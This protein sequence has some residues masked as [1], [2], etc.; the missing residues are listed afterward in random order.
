MDESRTSL[1]A[2]DRMFDSNPDGELD[3]TVPAWAATLA[4]SQ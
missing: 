2:D 3:H 4:N 1:A